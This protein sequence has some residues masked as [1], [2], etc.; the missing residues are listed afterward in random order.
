MPEWRIRLVIRSGLV[1]KLQAPVV[2]LCYDV[3]R[4][5]QRQP[6]VFLPITQSLFY[7]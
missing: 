2:R 5:L 7:I 4:V 3:S 1:T 6:N